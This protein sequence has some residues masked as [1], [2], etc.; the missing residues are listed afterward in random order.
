MGQPHAG[1][2]LTKDMVAEEGELGRQ[3]RPILFGDLKGYSR[4]AVTPEYVGTITT[5]REFET[6]PVYVLTSDA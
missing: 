6:I 4:L 3:V 1:Q 5:A 2:E